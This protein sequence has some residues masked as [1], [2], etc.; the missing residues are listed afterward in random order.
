MLVFPS[1]LWHVMASLFILGQARPRFDSLSSKCLVQSCN[2]YF[3]GILSHKLLLQAG[4]RVQVEC[5]RNLMKLSIAS[6]L[7]P[8]NMLAVEAI[9]ESAFLEKKKIVHW[10]RRWACSDFCFPSCRW[11]R[12]QCANPQFSCSVWVQHGVRPLGQ[13][14]DL[15]LS[16]G[17]LCGE[18][19]NLDH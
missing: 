18:Q 12:C 8:G 13:H 7:E 2:A 15:H 6:A 4:N 9:S 11:H 5:L 14:Q 17:L 10:C 19:S 16:A 3:F 1:L